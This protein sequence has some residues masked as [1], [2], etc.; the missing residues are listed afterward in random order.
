MQQRCINGFLLPCVGIQNLSL[1]QE[2]DPTN[3]TR[4]RCA[5]FRSSAHVYAD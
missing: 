5:I 4:C 2:V 1:K 3:Q